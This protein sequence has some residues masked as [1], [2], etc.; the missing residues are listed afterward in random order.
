MVTP[1][2][3]SLQGNLLIIVTKTQL[4]QILER[5]R[6]LSYRV[7]FFTTRELGWRLH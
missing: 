3:S 7:F 5:T 2:R 1:Q 4:Q 6:V